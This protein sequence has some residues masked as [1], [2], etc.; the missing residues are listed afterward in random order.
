M[1]G[2]AR[3]LQR[4]VRRQLGSAG[5]GLP[6]SLVHLL[7]AKDYTGVGSKLPS[8]RG[9]DY[10]TSYAGPMYNDAGN[11]VGAIPVVHHDA[12]GN[13]KGVWGAPA[14]TQ[15]M[16]YSEPIS[17]AAW[18]TKAG[19]SVEAAS[20][21]LAEF[22]SHVTVFGDNS[23]TR[24]SYQSID[25]VATSQIL[26]FYI[27][28]D[29]GGVPVIG[30]G[31]G[32]GDFRIVMNGD[33]VSGVVKQI[34]DT[35]YLIHAPIAATGSQARF[36]VL[37]YSDQSVRSFKCTRFNVTRTGS[38]MPYV[39]SAGSAVSVV[40]AAGNTGGNGASLTLDARMTSA[41]SGVCTIAALVWPGATSAQVTADTNI[42]AARNVVTDVL[43]WASGG[44]I[45]A[46]DGTNT[47]EVTVTGGW[48]GTYPIAVA[49][50][51]NTAGTQMQ[52]GY[53]KYSAAGQPTAAAWTWGGLGTFKGTF[54]PVI[55]RAFLNNTIPQWLRA[56]ETWNKSA[57]EAEIDKQLVRA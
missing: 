1:A 11:S 33:T 15:H 14:F 47:V 4:G 40:S 21:W 7:Y 27:E 38:L 36:G 44:K 26:S 37:K 2:L 19:I 54:S 41:L 46:S 43:Y 34:A 12:A 49:T 24:A 13:I 6:S 45:K 17:D 53:R 16:P 52:V 51:T 28:M 39:K 25:N 32:T 30:S 9:P 56:V 42:I 23:T 18:T 29:D 31:G 10:D 20:G 48:D 22:S 5:G 8:R 55:L 3:A 50:R 57:S 35:V